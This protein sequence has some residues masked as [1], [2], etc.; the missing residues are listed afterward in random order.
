MSALAYVEVVTPQA[1]LTL[2]S[3]MQ[4]APRREFQSSAGRQCYFSSQIP[5]LLPFWSFVLWLVQPQPQPQPL[6]NLPSL[7]AHSL[8][9]STF[10]HPTNRL[11]FS[12]PSI[13][14]ASQQTHPTFFSPR[15][16]LAK[17]KRCDPHQLVCCPDPKIQHPIQILPQDLT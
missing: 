5:C 16:C 8:L 2:K 17:E 14:L 7:I 1:S 4:L 13:L 6:T 15:L 12:Q 11:R 3:R 9:Q 10:S